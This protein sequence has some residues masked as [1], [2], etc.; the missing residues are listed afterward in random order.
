MSDMAP[1]TI[2]ELKAPT[3]DPGVSCIAVVAD[4]YALELSY[5]IARA[6]G[7]AFVSFTDPLIHRFGAPND[8]AR[9]GHPL[10][11]LGLQH[12]AALE[13]LNS[14]WIAELARQN[15]V[16]PKHSPGLYSGYRH[17]VWTFHDSTFE[18]VAS[19]FSVRIHPEPIG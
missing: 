8:E 12:Y 1:P 14:P 9:S 17:F 10:F 2:I 19:D 3:I 18:C 16:H 4:E 7:K 11:N 13:V 15:E 6:G 5:A